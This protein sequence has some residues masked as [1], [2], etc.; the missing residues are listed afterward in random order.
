MRNVLESSLAIR[1]EKVHPT[2]TQRAADDRRQLSRDSK[3]AHGDGIV[4]VRHQLCML[5]RHNKH[6]TVSDRLYVHERD[7]V[8]VLVGE[9]GGRV[10]GQDLAEDALIAQVRQR[11]A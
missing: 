2:R 7:D 10:P 8:V 4:Q 9:A 1:H 6:V 11:E 5:S 3:R